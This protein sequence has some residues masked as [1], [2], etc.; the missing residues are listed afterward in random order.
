MNSEFHCHR[1]HL[2]SHTAP[3]PDSTATLFVW[4]KGSE[5][6]AKSPNSQTSLGADSWRRGSSTMDYYNLTI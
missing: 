2:C 1:H 3:S 4:C 5:Q 6:N